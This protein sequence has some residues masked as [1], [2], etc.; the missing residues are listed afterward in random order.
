MILSTINAST[1]LGTSSPN[2]LKGTISFTMS[3]DKAPPAGY[4]VNLDGKLDDNSDLG[5][6][7]VF[8]F[9]VPAGK[10]VDLN[11][12][13]AEKDT[14]DVLAWIKVSV[15]DDPTVKSASTEYWEFWYNLDDVNSDDWNTLVQLFT[16]DGNIYTYRFTKKRTGDDI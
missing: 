12:S 2:G 3:T 8:G 16:S 10:R 5:Y 7:M 1:P 15:V 14:S 4:G 11:N 6:A 13:G 9:T